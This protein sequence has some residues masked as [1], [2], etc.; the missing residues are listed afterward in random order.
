MNSQ[1]ICDDKFNWK[2]KKIGLLNV[3][4]I[5][6]INSVDYLV[7]KIEGVRDIKFIQLEKILKSLKGNFSIVV[8][9]DDYIF[10]VVDRISGYRL[11][12]R[13]DSLG[14]VISNAPRKLLS[15]QKKY[16]FNNNSIIE[17]NMS[18][19]VS[20]NETIDKKISKLCAGQLILCNKKTRKFSVNNYY[21]FFHHGVRNENDD[22]LIEELDTITNSIINRN[23]EDANGKT[24]WV[25]LS[26]GL[27]SRLIL[28]K[29]KQFGYDDIR[30]Y[31]YGVKGNFD[32]I[33]AKEVSTKL[34][35]RWNFFPTKPSESRQYFLSQ[36]RKDYWNFADGL[37]SVP[38]LHGMFALKSLIKSHE[39][40]PND[41]VINGQSGDFI[42]GQHIPVFKENS[43]INDELLLETILN[44][45]YSH[46]LDMINNNDLVR[47]IKN[48]ISKSLGKFSHINNYQEFAKSYEY[49]EWKGRQANR[50]INGQCNYDF[51][52]LKW[53]LP[54]WDLEYLEFWK[55]I[56]IHQKIGRRLFVYYL[57]KTNPYELFSGQEK[58]MSRWPL[59][60]IYIQFI[61]NV[62]RLTLGKKVSNL[63]Y[64]RLDR[65][66]QYQ[67]LYELTSKYEYLKNW[68]NYRSI[69]PYLTD[70]W[71][72]ENQY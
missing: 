11:F 57:N 43:K 30:T 15:N 6:N 10:G 28:C 58:F 38:N 23:I 40:K 17:I 51:L 21:S 16:D 41:I 2:T 25:P 13:D 9:T 36:D 63:Y 54:L 4:F 49:W 67:Y 39:M 18:G 53:E 8:E 29:L 72:E 26:G 34:N 68:K 71:L 70:V 59:N 50:V 66:S 32:A 52:G 20:G 60:R 46:R 45:H 64:K 22:N 61:G 47:K 35:I 14:C 27:D 55:D 37:S 5:G 1:F 7:S 31:S 42:S 3:S 19:Y 33:R 44:K 12:Y 62:A 24:I 56:P 48:N 65:Y 69:Y